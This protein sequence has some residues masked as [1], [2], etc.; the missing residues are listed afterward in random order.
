VPEPDIWFHFLIQRLKILNQVPKN[1]IQYLIPAASFC[2]S[3]PDSQA[4]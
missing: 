1:L 4:K 3:G 2:L